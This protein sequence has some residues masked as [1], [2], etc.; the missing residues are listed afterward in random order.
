MSKPLITLEDWIT[1]SGKYKERLKSPELTEEVKNNATRL[2]KK[3]NDVLKELNI[4]EIKVSSGFRPTNINANIK[5]AA[6]KSG[7]TR[8]LAIDFVDT[9]EKLDELLNSDKSQDLLEKHGIWQEHPS[10][11]KGWSHWDIIERPIKNR[12]GCK[13]RQFNP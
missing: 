9:N 8:G 4:T 10:K 2:L 13:K 5:G 1:A 6:P 7:H 12:P 3:V 11:T